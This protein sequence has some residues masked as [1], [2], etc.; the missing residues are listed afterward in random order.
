MG[1]DDQE[2]PRKEEDAITFRLTLE[3]AV[4]FLPEPRRQQASQVDRLGE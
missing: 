4:L 2:A 1:W 3:T